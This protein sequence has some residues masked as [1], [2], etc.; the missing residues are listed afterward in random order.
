MCRTA[1]TVTLDE[2]LPLSEQSVGKFADDLRRHLEKRIDRRYKVRGVEIHSVEFQWA[3]GSEVFRAL[4]K[5]ET[6]Q[7]GQVVNVFENIG[8]PEA[9]LLVNDQRC[10]TWMLG[11]DLLDDDLLT[12]T[13][14]ELVQVA[15][16]A[17]TGTWQF[18]NTKLCCNNRS[19]ARGDKVKCCNTP[20]RPRKPRRKKLQ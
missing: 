4:V 2:R 14:D 8:G 10:G 7:G 17:L 15:E 18:H 19:G 6:R 13:F 1:F 20:A 5:S 9:H 16:L 11:C 12:S 3:K